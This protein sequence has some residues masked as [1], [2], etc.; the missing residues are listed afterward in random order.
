MGNDQQKTKP[1]LPIS[2]SYLMDTSFNIIKSSN[3]SF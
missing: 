3:R 1:N 2:L